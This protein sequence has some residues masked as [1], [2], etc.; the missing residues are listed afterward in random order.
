MSDGSE[1]RDLLPP[2]FHPLVREWF[3]ATYGKPT[4]VQAGSWPVIA[5]G[6][7]VLALAPTGSGKTLTAF[8]AALSRFC[9]PP[10]GVNSGGP[11]YPADRLSVLYVSPLKALNEDIRRN[12]LEPLA[13][14]RARFEGAGLPFPGI[15]VETRSADTPRPERRR[16]HVSPPSILALTPESLAIILLNPKGR[17]VL[18]QVKYVILDEIHS[19][20]GTKRGS[21]LSC[22]IERLAL[23]AGEFQR[24]SLSATV[25]PPRAASEFIG[26]LKRAVHIIAPREEKKIVF[27][28]DFPA[29][30]AG[31]DADAGIY[32][33]AGKRY[34]VLTDLVL[35]KIESRG[36]EGGAENGKDSSL[37]VFTDS[38][39][40][41]ERLA[42]LVN[43]KAGRVAAYAHHG[44]LSKEIRRTVETRFAEGSLPC[45]IATSSLELGIDIGAVDEVFLAGSPSSVWQTL[46]RTGRS[47]HGA[48]RTSRGKLIPFHGMDLLLAAGLA[49]AVAEK[50]IEET[51]PVENPLD[52]LA[53]IILS[54][55]AERN[56]N[57]DELYDLLRGF[58]VFRTLRRSSYD[59]VIAM[60]TETYRKVREIRPRL[61]FDRTGRMLSAAPGVLELLYTQGGVIANRGYYS[62]RLAGGR[63][64]GS[65]DGPG[66]KIGELDEEF[67]W[68]RRTG[69]CFNFG[70][71][72]WR[73]TAIGA[74]AVEVV[75]LDRPVNYVPFWRAEKAFRSP[76]LVQ[77]ILA[78]LEKY[79]AAAGEAF[80][81]LIPGFSKNAAKSL[82]RFLDSQY[83]ALGSLP[84]RNR[85]CVEIINE[86]GMYGEGRMY[87]VVLHT[88]RGGAVNYPFSLAVAGALEERL[89]ARIEVFSDDDGILIIVPGEAAEAE[90]LLEGVLGDLDNDGGGG[91]SRGERFFRKRLESSGI[92]G[93]AFREAAERSL[94]ISGPLFGKRMP[95]WITRQK[96]RRLFD[97]VSGEDG[98]PVTAEA[99][100][101]CLKDM[102]DMEGFRELE[103][104]IGSGDVELRFSAVS[105]PSPFARGLVRQEINTFMYEYDERKE[106]RRTS[107]GRGKEV[108]L[109]DRAIARALGEASLRPALGAALV[110]DFTGRLRR[111]IPGWT[112]EDK[113]SLAEWVKE[114]IALPLDE[115]EILTAAL[116]AEL[117]K[118]VEKDPSLGGRI[119]LFKTEIP[120]GGEIN[121]V[122]VMIH[123][124]WE[125]AWRNPS[126]RLGL[127]GPWLRYEGPISISRIAAVFGA[128]YSEA[129]D[130]VHALAESGEA[131]GD[132]SVTDLASDLA[133]D[134]GNLDLLLRL[135]RK[136]A[137]PPVRERPAALLA[138]F[139]AMRQGILNG[140]RAGQPWESI[141][142]LSA[143]ARLWETEFFPARKKDYSPETLDGALREGSLLWYG[144][145]KERTGF[146]AP[147][148]LDLASP[149][150]G[151]NKAAGDYTPPALDVR[152][153]DR[154]RDFWEIREA[155]KTGNRGAAEIIWNETWKGRL[156]ADSWEPVRRGLA[157]GFIP[158]GPEGDFRAE[159]GGFSQGYPYGAVRRHIPRALREKWRGGPPVRGLWY[160]LL[161]DYTADPFEEEELNRDRVRLLIR[162]RGIICRPF[163][164]REAPPFSWQA[165]LPVI[166]RMELAG[167]L[168]AG[169]FFSGINSLQFAPPSIERE[170][171]EAEASR[172]TY[173]MN[174]SDPASIAGLSVEGLDPRLPARSPFNR[175]CFRGENLIAVS[176]KGGRELR[177][178]PAPGR[179]SKN[180]EE[181]A[182]FSAAP[183]FRRVQPERKIVI[184]RINGKNAASSEYSGAFREQGF[185]ADRGKLILW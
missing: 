132:V 120:A 75:P 23:I 129:E 113:Q 130:A 138:P 127:L 20:L 176:L 179:D 60:L 76:V 27:T 124:E 40:R 62:L 18:S 99:W 34:R 93:A 80:C 69:D 139:L 67:V 65:G 134:T 150:G 177:I 63:A 105:R 85:I 78:V 157:E 151:A 175:L 73:I 32:A 103:S 55:C 162:R 17:K 29:E 183:R 58:H 51:H 126:T 184:E 156:S 43:E 37:L 159:D 9:A 125:E 147:G 31:E 185:T 109:S 14:I 95:L 172:E 166:R 96:S 74:E 169:R 52:I 30:D 50:E 131:A 140:P 160:S 164:E 8:L 90:V 170:L 121:A 42:F 56:Y 10:A 101:S 15:R 163:L 28:V 108:S 21:F 141:S 82:A 165:L 39:Q 61:Y 4:A 167:E 12:L 100:R 123:R 114:R 33:G 47:G 171:E 24:V 6:G 48:G 119:I 111:E 41:S 107:S 53:Q 180:A 68:E 102:F 16:F 46:Q 2:S 88:F 5:E 115:W 97:A 26:G 83:A 116:P 145:G 128:E 54:L 168:T 87:P 36:K 59:S 94:L 38:R 136:K 158:E 118:E 174:A 79:D 70:S 66:T 49:G 137:R 1:P 133:C 135:A 44:S 146:S 64:G 86:M 152:F 154:P 144:D 89:A 71:R 72:G 122:P 11:E 161:P 19:V 178:F 104:G 91:I 110:S 149:W 142:C 173:W 3:T 112:A 7:H 81:A 13:G 45:V 77:R 117:K 84:G 181:A 98:F 155:L 25:R 143:P 57:I 153:F 182:A 22:Q 148:D 106:L 92:F 35:E